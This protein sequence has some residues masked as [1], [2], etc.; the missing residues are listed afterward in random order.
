MQLSHL[1]SRWLGA[2]AFVIGAQAATASAQ[3]CT[4][5][6]Q[7]A[8]PLACK[9]G[10]TICSGGGGMSV[11]GGM[12]V[13]DPVCETEPAACTWVL[14]ACQTDANCTQ[15]SWTCML[16]EGA[17][18]TTHICF[19]KGIACATDAACPAG[20]SCVD[21]A[22]V[23]EKDL[24]A[25]WTATGSTKFCWPDVLRG[26]PDKTTPVDSTHL[27]ITGVS[28]GGTETPVRGAADEG[29]GCS[30]LGQGAGPGLWLAVAVGLAWRIG[31]KRRR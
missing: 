5:D 28:G 4:T 30:M 18:P 8:S 20:W 22:T 3:P 2:I 24:A 27:G 9:P 10:A 15:P 25:M 11:D 16:L 21:F 7:C 12:T 19:P 17:Q 31:R 29:S 6:A 1:A 13:S 23:A 14:G 26:V